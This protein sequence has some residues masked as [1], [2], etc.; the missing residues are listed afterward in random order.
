MEFPLFYSRVSK[1]DKKHPGLS[2]QVQGEILRAFAIRNIMA[3][4]ETFEDLGVSAGIPLQRR[5]AGGKLIAALKARPRPVVVTRLDRLFRRVDDGSYWL[6]RWAREGVRFYSVAETIDITTPSGM[7]LAHMLLAAAEYEHQVAGQRTRAVRAKLKTDGKWLG[8]LPPYGFTVGAGNVLMKD[9]H[10]QSVRAR[11]LRMHSFGNGPERIA[12]QLNAEGVLT[13]GGK[14]WGKSTVRAILAR[15]GRLRKSAAA[16]VEDL[17]G[18]A[19]VVDVAAILEASKDS[20]P[21]PN[22]ERTERNE[23]PQ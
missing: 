22:V 19:D 21:L 23:D 18:G 12:K 13:R 14:A 5:P 4:G 6:R 15:A 11:I 3:G 20:Q 7:L 16:A 17:V 10:E 9:P 8:G 2:P 1:E